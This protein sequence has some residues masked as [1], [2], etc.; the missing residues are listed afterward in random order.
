MGDSSIAGLW[1]VFGMGL[2]Q[3]NR[4]AP[5]SEIWLRPHA[6]LAMSGEPFPDCNMAVI[7]VGG[8]VEGTLR[9]FVKRLRERR[10]PALFNISSAAAPSLHEIALSL[11]LKQAGLIP[12]MVRESGDAGTTHRSSAGGEAS[13]HRAAGPS[14]LAAVASVCAAAFDQDVSSMMRMLDPAILKLPGLELF[15]AC[16]GDVP[17]SAVA[18]TE[19]GGFVGVWAMATSPEHQ[20]RGHGRTALSFVLR[21]HQGRAKCFYLTASP[22]G[23]HLYEELGFV[24]VERSAAWILGPPGQR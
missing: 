7:D 23:Q 10:L 4:S 14:D 9:S 20:R 24:T 8:E 1:A 18:T 17:V 2:A 3:L 21:H 6:V 19:H 15:L 11:G 5:D 13:V 22:Q 16:R 12:L